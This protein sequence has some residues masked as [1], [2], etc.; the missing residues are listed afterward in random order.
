[1]LIQFNKIK[2]HVKHTKRIFPLFT[3]NTNTKN[4]YIDININGRKLRISI[5]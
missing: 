4:A 2:Y 3:Y 5:H 1:M